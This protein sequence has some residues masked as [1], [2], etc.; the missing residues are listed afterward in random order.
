MIRTEAQK[1]R[2]DGGDRRRQD[3]ADEAV[4]TGDAGAGRRTRATIRA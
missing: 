1:T 4:L 2:L 3:A